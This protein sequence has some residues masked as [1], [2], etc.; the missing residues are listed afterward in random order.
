MARTRGYVTPG[1]LAGS[2]GTA[3]AT[4]AAIGVDMLPYPP[5][6]ST[7]YYRTPPPTT[8][9]SVVANASGVF[10]AA[11]F[12]IPADT[13]IDRLGAEV[14]VIGDVGS[15]VRLGIYGDTG[16]FRPGTLTLDAGTIAG[17]S[18]TVQ[19]ITV[20]KLLT[21]GWYWFG[22]VAQTVTVTAPTVRTL[23]NIGMAGIGTSVVY[24]A[25]SSRF[26]YIKNGVTGALPASF[27]TP[28]GNSSNPIATFIRVQ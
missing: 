20:S 25:G 16:D 9:F 22:G 21:R 24:G 4:R 8:A 7:Y 27:G 1:V 14:T 6:V 5:F 11:P 26:G 18:A 19:Q 12:W 23:P 3:A 2:T 17:D 13:T 10:H 28:D 15:V